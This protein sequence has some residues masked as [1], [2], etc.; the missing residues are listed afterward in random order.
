MPVR[1]AK[2]AGVRFGSIRAKPPM[3]STGQRIGLL[4]GSFDPPHDAHVMISLIALRRLGLAAVWW[5]ATP[6]NPIKA[7]DGLAPLARRLEFC[8]RLARHP[9]IEVTAFEQAL[10]TAYTAATLAFLK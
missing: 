8:E 1:A 5:M 4:G 7:H 3:A 6:G 9:R 10:P 2:S